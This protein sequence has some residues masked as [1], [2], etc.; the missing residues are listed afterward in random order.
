MKLTKNKITNSNIAGNDLI[1][2]DNKE[3]IKLLN[4][5]LIEL[6]RINKKKRDK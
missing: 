6:K 5:I 4:K 1:I 3:V 2:N